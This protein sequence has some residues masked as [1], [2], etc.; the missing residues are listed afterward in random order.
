MKV[1]KSIKTTT[2]DGVAKLVTLTTTMGA[3]AA[4]SSSSSKGTT[5]ATTSSSDGS[6]DRA[7]LSA[8]QLA[9]TADILGTSGADNILLSDLTTNLRVQGLAGDDTIVTGNG[10]DTIDGGA[11]ND[12][13][14][15]GNGSDTIDGGDGNDI[16]RAGDGTDVVKGGAGNDS[17]E[18]GAGNDVIRG[19][20]GN[21]NIDAGAGDDLVVLI[22]ANQNGGSYVAADLTTG[23][24][25]SGVLTLAEV[26]DANQVDESGSGVTIDGGANSV[27]G[28]D[29]LVIFGTVDLSDITITGFENIAVNSDVTVSAAQATALATGGA[30][31]G[32][33]VITGDGSSIVRIASETGNPV[34]VDLKCFNTIWCFTN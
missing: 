5:A 7:N 11:G 28:A 31:G 19:G 26:N 30:S 1:F 9:G 22:G 12:T 13:I 4:C 15:S 2:V 3:L 18:G 17:I 25:V 10:D 21:D 8:E 33:V 23:Q 16:I 24:D 32:A 29:T 27:S 34:T 20:A 14:T 6:F